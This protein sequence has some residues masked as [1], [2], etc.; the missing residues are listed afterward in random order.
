[1]TEM[2]GK[3]SEAAERVHRALA[4]PSRRRLMSQL[5]EADGLLGVDE[6]A[7][8]TGLSAATVRHHLA[9]LADA[10]LVRATTVAGPGRGRPKLRYTAV[11]AAPGTPAAPGLPASSGTPDGPEG[12]A[13]HDLAAALAEALATHA[14][15]KPAARAAG[16]TW[17][18][19]LAASDTPART[20]A[21]TPAPAG[22][23]GAT[24]WG[25]V[26]AHA[27]RSGFEPEEAPAPDGTR[28]VLLRGCPYRD[29][30][31][32]RPEVICSVHQGVLD[33]LLDGTGTAAELR[34][35]VGPELCRADLRATS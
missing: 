3:D 22:Q 26:F 24:T 9:S 20:P 12:R 28:R 30:A 6:L 16:R 25:R 33:G 1:M 4:V 7:A 8:A 21:G 13:D 17:G 14:D 29:L 10:G 31:R 5:R 27:A 32:A 34:P 23:R 2:T 11:R 35:F 18:H 19:E 15:A